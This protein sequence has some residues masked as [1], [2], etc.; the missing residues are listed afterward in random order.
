MDGHF[1]QGPFAAHPAG[2]G[3]VEA[4]LAGIPGQRAGD[5]DDVG[6]EIL[7]QRDPWRAVDEALAVEE[8]RRE[9]LVVAGRAHGDRQR[10]AVDPELE[11]LLDRDLVGEAG[12]LHD[13]VEPSSPDL[14]AAGHAVHDR[15]RDARLTIRQRWPVFPRRW[16]EGVVGRRERAPWARH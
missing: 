15:G 8:P 7:A 6:G 13:G 12:V 2:G 11:R 9:L 10:A 1:F 3:G 4:P 5:L 16:G 14:G